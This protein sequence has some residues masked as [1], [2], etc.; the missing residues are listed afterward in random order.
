MRFSSIDDYFEPGC[1]LAEQLGDEVL[2]RDLEHQEWL[3]RNLAANREDRALE[4]ARQDALAAGRAEPSDDDVVR[5]LTTLQAAEKDLPP[6]D[7]WA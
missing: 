1:T 6:D 2:R 5:W 4:E 3:L 7:C